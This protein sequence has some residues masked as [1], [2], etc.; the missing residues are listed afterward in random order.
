MLD[1]VYV[2]HNDNKN[3]DGS[4]SSSESAS[5]GGISTGNTINN[6]NHKETSTGKATPKVR[7]T[8]TLRGIKD[9]ANLQIQL[10]D[11]KPSLS[12]LKPSSTP[13]TA[14]INTSKMKKDRMPNVERH[15]FFGRVGEIDEQ[16]VQ[17]QCQCRQWQ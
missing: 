7:V 6:G 9:L 15:A 14:V 4:E 8:P 3:H 2:D 10:S 11:F 5:S 13:F 1:C 17:Q 16:V 12:A